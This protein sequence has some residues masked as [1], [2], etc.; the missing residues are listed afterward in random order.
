MIIIIHTYLLNVD[1][2]YFKAFF[3]AF[4]IKFK[5]DGL[6]YFDRWTYDTENYI[7]ILVC[8]Y[9]QF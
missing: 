8:T 2:F 4:V 9:E 3:F 5:S 7:I 1:K 6:K